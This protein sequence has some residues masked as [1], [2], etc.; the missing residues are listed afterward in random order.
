MIDTSRAMARRWAGHLSSR[1]EA[2]NSICCPF[3][4]QF[5]LSPLPESGSRGTYVLF[6]LTYNEKLLRV[7]A[8][9]SRGI[10]QEQPRAG[11]TCLW[12]APLTSR[13]AAFAEMA[14]FH[15]C[16]RFWVHSSGSC[17]KGPRPCQSALEVPG[18]T[19]QLLNAFGYGLVPGAD[20]GLRVM[21]DQVL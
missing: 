14:P 4:F 10:L 5:G 2:L 9:P 3:I 11:I 12:T 6:H 13:W 15:W 17:V 7:A 16:H 1:H 19:Y 18:S 21:L 8:V 20:A